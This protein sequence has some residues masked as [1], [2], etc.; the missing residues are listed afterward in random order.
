MSTVSYVYLYRPLRVD[1]R[2]QLVTFDS[3]IY[4]IPPSMLHNLIIIDHTQ[5]VAC[6]IDTPISQVSLTVFSYRIDTQKVEIT[7]LSE[8]AYPTTTASYALRLHVGQH[9]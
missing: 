3:R 9:A 4:H 2:Q 1:S 7:L 8:V 6:L 5:H